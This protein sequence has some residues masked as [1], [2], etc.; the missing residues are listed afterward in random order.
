MTILFYDLV[1]STA[2]GARSDPEDYSEAIDR[3]HH[4]IGAAMR[5][6]GG[7]VGARVGDGAVVY[8]GYPHAQED[9][10][11]RAVL[12]GLRAVEVSAE[13]LMPGGD[14]ALIRVGVATG[15]GIINHAEDDA[16]GNEVVGSVANLAARLQ[17]AAPPGC[18]VVSDATRRLV[19]SQF[20]VEDLGGVQAKGFQSP[21][22]AWRVIGANHRDR[23][24]PLEGARETPMVGRIR[25]LERL[26]LALTAAEAGEGRVVLLTGEPGLGKSR[27]AADF[28][29]RAEGRGALRINLHGSAHSREAPLRPFIRQLQRAGGIDEHTGGAASSLRGLA[30]GTDADETA[31]L[32][33]LLGLPVAESPALQALTPARRLERT[34]EA[35]IHQLELF[36]HEK[37]VLVLFEDAHW[38]DPTSLTLLDRAVRG[39]R[40]GRALIMITARPEFQP[41]W[42]DSPMVD[43][44]SLSPMAVED[45]AALIYRIAGS[46][47]LAPSLRR[48]ILDRAD[49]VPLFIEELTRST[50]EVARDAGGNLTEDYDLPM[51]LQDSLLARLDRLGP[52]KEIA[53]IAA[54]IGR[55]FP[56]RLV[57]AL[58]DLDPAEKI[59]SLQRLV[60]SG[61]IE[62]ERDSDSQSYRFHHVLVQQTAYGALLRPERRRLNARLLQ[63]IET[64]QAAM[65]VAEPERL[66]HYAAEA[67]QPEASARYWL[68]AG[69]QALAQT[70][71]PEAS[72][73]L[74]RGLAMVAQL[75]QDAARWHIEL[76]LE[77]A[78]G[79]ALIATVGYALPETGAVFAS[80]KVLCEAIGEKPELLAVLHGLWIHDLLCGRLRSARARADELL[81]LAEAEQDESWTLIGCRARGVLGYPLGEFDIS[82]RMLERGLSLFAPERRPDYALV[83]VDDPRVVMLMYLS[84][85][86]VFL[87][88]EAT[89]RATIETC[90]AEARALGQ[91]Y[92][93]AHALAGRVLVGLFIED[94]EDL[95]PIIDELA[96][97]TSEHEIAFYAAVA[98]VLRGR[99]MS[100]TGEEDAGAQALGAALDAYRA[101][102]SIL[103]L[104]TFMM[105]RAD[106]MGRSG[107]IEDALALIGQAK[108]LIEQTG[109]ENDASE[110]LRVEGEIQ[111][112]NGN[113][114]GAASAFEAALAIATRQEAVLY[115]TRARASLVSMAERRRPM[116]IP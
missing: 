28:A 6:F 33:R 2:L 59:R 3:F 16:G 18:V 97:L 41:S 115:V 103:Y 71:M 51:T 116:R 85:V 94:Y 98:E 101:T 11:E 30:P 47:G 72:A 70:A 39:G 104:P 1:G 24:D 10:A 84:W 17:S 49:G 15:Q 19:A 43:E 25:E 20:D 100:R 92:N 82:R 65:V 32:S 87:G 78:L 73:R 89:A 9:A 76:K 67:G 58:S 57:D 106:A 35:L 8:F 29:R 40:F 7:Y 68:A 62:P 12:A 55:R 75:P 77:L 99:Y 50:L 56:R 95:L 109:M 26:D 14:A 34:V 45:G 108:A 53:Q 27:L 112:A 107:R 80:A 74:R 83:L 69:L 114:S 44:I 64:E 111:L 91:P 38:A 4:Q 110:I 42:R 37:V 93:L 31:L 113:A 21:V 88:E 46:H 81:Q 60:E 48:A 5:G 90:V 61:L 96:S 63:L 105:W 66:A 36:S 86:L 102:G 13:V 54:V 79:K 52:A 23:F 22:H